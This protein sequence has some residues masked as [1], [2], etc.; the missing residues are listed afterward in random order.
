MRQRSWWLK[1]PADIIKDVPALPP[2]NADFFIDEGWAH[3]QRPGNLERS[4][5]G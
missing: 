3:R 4:L 5:P 1:K 2:S